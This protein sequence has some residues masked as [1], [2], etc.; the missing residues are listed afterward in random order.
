MTALSDAETVAV[1]DAVAEVWDGDGEAD[2]DAEAELDCEGELDREGERIGEGEAVGEGEADRGG[3][4]VRVFVVLP[5]GLA[6]GADVVAEPLGDGEGDGEGFRDG[7]GEGVGEGDGVLEVGSTWH[8]L[9]VLAAAV[10][11]GVAVPGL[12]ES[13]CAVPDQDASAPATTDPPATKL[14]VV[15]RTCPKRTD[16]ALST[17]LVTV[18]VCSS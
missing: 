5:L 2:P 16:L 3:L 10:G 14:S 8:V 15:A 12:S 17:L 7:L 9:P 1:A 4:G 18:T 11:L 6:A 13:A